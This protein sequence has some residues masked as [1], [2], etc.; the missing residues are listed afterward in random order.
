[1]A[2]IEQGVA[3]RTRHRGMLTC[4]RSDYP[5]E[6]AN[7]ICF[8]LAVEGRAC[9]SRAQRFDLFWN[10][11]IAPTCVYLLFRSRAT[12]KLCT[13][14]RGVDIKVAAIS[15]VASCRRQQF[16]G[17]DDSDHLALWK[18]ER[19]LRDKLQADAPE[20]VRASTLHACCHQLRQKGKASRDHTLATSLQKTRLK[21]HSLKGSASHSKARVQS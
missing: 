14:P 10:S 3:N 13:K 18:V 2:C 7:N 19:E 15:T 17:C 20:F 21:E 5:R 8:A 6:A 1:M 11:P 4:M 16:E 12:L 9:G